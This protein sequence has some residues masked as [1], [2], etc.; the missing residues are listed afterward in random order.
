VPA[1]TLGHIFLATAAIELLLVLVFAARVRSAHLE[2]PPERRSRSVYV[3]IAAVI[4]S[5]LIL[6]VLAFVLPEA[7]MRLV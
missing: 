7:R 1:I 2:L 4:V 6:C 3:V 5:S